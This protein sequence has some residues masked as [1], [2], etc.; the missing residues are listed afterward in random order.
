TDLFAQSVT[1]Y[2]SLTGT[3]NSDLSAFRN[4]GGKLLSWQGLTDN[5]LFP[6][7]V[8]KYRREVDKS[9]GGWESVNNFYRLFFVPGVNH[10]GGGYGPWPNDPLGA[11][12]EW[13]EKG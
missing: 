7:A 10:C 4:A 1:Q 12:V 8:L 3:H 9:L 11:L 5:I 6:Q 2:D 13:V